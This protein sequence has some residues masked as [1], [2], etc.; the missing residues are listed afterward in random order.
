MSDNV[1]S[2][3]E[4]SH[5]LMQVKKFEEF[6]IKKLQGIQPSKFQ[7]FYN[8]IKVNTKHNLNRVVWHHDHRF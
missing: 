2:K 3:H 7:D 4:S 6:I 5:K 8:F 1:C